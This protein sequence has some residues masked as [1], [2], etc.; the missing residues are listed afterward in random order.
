MVDF[1][2]PGGIGFESASKP[3]TVGQIMDRRP[4]SRPAKKSNGTFFL[5][6]IA[7]DLGIL[8]MAFCRRFAR[9]FVKAFTPLALLIFGAAVKLAHSVNRRVVK[10]GIKSYRKSVSALYIFKMFLRTTL[11]IAKKQGLIYS[12]LYFIIRSLKSLK[13]NRR[14]VYTALNHISPVA[15]AF[16]FVFVLNYWN[17]VT[18]AVSINYKGVDV[19]CVENESVYE[20]AL[21]QMSQRIVSDGKTDQYVSVPEFTLKKVKPYEMVDSMALCN[22]LIETS[23]QEITDACGL[24]IDDSFAGALKNESDARGLLDGVLN[25]Y[26]D[27]YD[28]EVILFNNNI[29]YRIGLYPVNS[30]RTVENIENVLLGGKPEQPDELKAEAP[31]DEK[32]KKDDKKE[33]IATKKKGSMLDV[34]VVRMEEYDEPV[35]FQT[36]YDEDNSR[37]EGY[38]KVTVEGIPGKKLITAQVTYVN[39]GETD[40]FVLKE[41]VTKKPVDQRIAVGTEQIHGLFIWPVNGGYISDYFGGYRNHQG[42]DI[43]A[44]YATDIYAANA[45]TVIFAGDQFNGYGIQVLI[46]HGNGY[47]TR[48]GHC[49]RVNVNIGDSVS[50]NEII[51]EVGSTG[52]STGNH[53][54]FEIIKG[55]V[56]QDPAPFLGV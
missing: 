55:G 31:P 15:A 56:N 3:D 12:I 9:G 21:A 54:H 33:E 27:G 16:V 24:Y 11:K 4:P 30:V 45:G 23:G 14:L 1:E 51:A 10:P 20:D 19:G 2:Q 47:Q 35:D 17:S 46:D 32:P 52:Y 18:F 42:L 5:N 7:Y 34:K 50:V 37:Y 40:R 29:Q 53:L 28:E 6:N 13:A 41:K 25:S 26:K 22:D 43:A 8:T 39:G 38:Q 48:Y 49:S 36:V 44:P